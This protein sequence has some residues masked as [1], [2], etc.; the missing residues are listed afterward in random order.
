M[1]SAVMVIDMQNGF[2]DKEGSLRSIGPALPGIDAVIQETRALLAEVRGAGLPVVYTRHR[3]RRGFVDAPLGII[4]RFPSGTKPLEE[5]SWDTARLAPEPGDVIVG[6]NR[7]DAFLYTD[8]ELILRAL[9]VR[10]PLVTGVVTN[11]CVSRPWGQPT[12][13]TTW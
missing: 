6:K 9:G 3:W 8:L 1:D 5:G 4:E 12:C 2:V 10:R 13:A 11:V 7:Y